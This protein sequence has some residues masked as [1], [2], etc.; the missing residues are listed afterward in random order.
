MTLGQFQRALSAMTIQPDLA[1][2][3]RRHGNSALHDYDLTPLERTR[4]IS[5]SRQQG[6]NLNCT[7][8]RGN[9]F[10][11][12]YD[13]LP[14]VCTLLKP[15]LRNLLDEFWSTYQPN[16]Y[17]LS[18]EAEAFVN[19]LN[20]KLFEGFTHP[21]L[22][23]ILHYES[24]SWAL[25]QSLRHS[26][27]INSTELYHEMVFTHD[28]RILLP[29]LEAGEFPCTDLPSGNF[30]VLLTLRGSTLIAELGKLLPIKNED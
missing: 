29:L 30:P 10:S 23:E 8:A 22:E 27:D 18:G 6:M 9:R 3:I 5:V 28:P 25:V 13:V 20:K 19:F 15:S 12:I 11:L 2:R 17:Q 16:N 1:A 14:L 4:L 24:A 21:Y 26:E 7:L